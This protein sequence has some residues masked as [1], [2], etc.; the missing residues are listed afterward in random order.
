MSHNDGVRL[1]FP[2]LP[3]AWV[4]RYKPG[5]M[6]RNQES[7]P[8]LPVPP[9]QQTLKKYLTSVEVGVSIHY[10]HTRHSGPDFINPYRIGMTL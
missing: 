3:P 8:K 7:L 5:Q 6:Y 1:Q 4:D 2:P 9:L 10:M